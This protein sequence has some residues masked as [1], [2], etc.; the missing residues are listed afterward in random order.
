MIDDELENIVVA[1]RLGLVAPSLS[2]ESRTQGFPGIRVVVADWL[3]DWR[4]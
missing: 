1:K 3:A 4:R 2:F